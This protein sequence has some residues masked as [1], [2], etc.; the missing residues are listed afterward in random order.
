MKLK[1]GVGG[2]LKGYTVC[3]IQT[4]IHFSVLVPYIGWFLFWSH[5]C[6]RQL[7]FF[8]PF[9]KRALC[10]LCSSLPTPVNLHKCCLLP[11]GAAN[12]ALNSACTCVVLT[13]STHSHVERCELT[14][15]QKWSAMMQTLNDLCVSLFSMEDQVKSI[16]EECNL[17][18]VHSGSISCALKWLLV[19]HIKI[20]ACE[21][22][23]K[24]GRIDW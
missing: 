2:E 16:S 4:L 12:T 23:E 24:L 19:Q 5:G 3:S 18:E 10:L 9:E 11:T 17:P 22:L 14:M 6:G 15:V 20:S 13:L 21:H 1:R 7:L 8:D